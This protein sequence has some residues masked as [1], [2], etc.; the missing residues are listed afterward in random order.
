MNST[1][2]KFRHGHPERFDDKVASHALVHGKAHDLPVEQILPLESVSQG[3][4]CFISFGGRYMTGILRA[5]YM[6]EFK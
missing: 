5:R 1:A 3:C 2:S 4:I 6:L